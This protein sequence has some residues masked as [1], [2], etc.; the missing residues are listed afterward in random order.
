[1]GLIARW[2]RNTNAIGNRQGKTVAADATKEPAKGGEPAKP[3]AL[4][5]AAVPPA[6]APP[7][8][9]GGPKG[10]E[11]TRYQDWERGGRCIDF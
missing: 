8:E 3:A 5:P 2:D 4:P 6:V 9:T 1:L 11:P 7:R 10:R